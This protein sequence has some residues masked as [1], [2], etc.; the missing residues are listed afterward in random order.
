MILESYR[1]GANTAFYVKN[2]DGSV[3]LC[4]YPEDKAKRID[5][6]NFNTESMVQVKFES[7]PSFLEFAEGLTMLSSASVHGLQIVRQERA[8][9][10]VKTVLWDGKGN[11]FTHR[12]TFHPQSNV[13]ETDVTY[14]NNS[15]ENRVLEH[16]SSFA[17]TG[18]K[19]L[20]S[21]KNTVEGCKLHRL[22][23]FWSA[24]GRK[25]TAP[26]E[27]LGLEDSW[28]NQ[29]AR[30]E[31]FGQVGSM[32]VRKYFPFAC[33]EE[34][35]GTCWAV[36]FEAPYSW[37][38]EVLVINGCAT[39][40]GGLADYEFGHWKKNIAPGQS[41][42]TRR[43]YLSVDSGF[44]QV[45][46]N[47]VDFYNKR[48]RVP[49]CEES[50]PIICNEYCTTYGNP[51]EDRVKRLALAAKELGAEYFIIDAGWYKKPGINWYY[52]IGDWQESPEFFPSGLK[53]LVGYIK[54]LGLKPGIWF[55]YENCAIDSDVY[56]DTSLLL[57]RNG[58]PLNTQ[59]RRFFDLRK[60][61]V[62]EYF[63]EKVIGFLR[64]NGF[65]YIKV[66]YNGNY[67][68]GCD[69]AE[70]EE[71][72]GRQVAEESIKMFAALSERIPGLVVENCS[73]GGHRLEPAR[74]EIASMASFSDAHECIE[75]PILAANVSRI[76]P[77]RQNQIWATLKNTYPDHRLYHLLLGNFYGR[78][79]LS[80]DIDTLT[81]GQ[82]K[83]CRE[84]IDFYRELVP[85][86]KEGR[87]I[88]LE[89]DVAG[90]RDPKGI[91]L[92]EIEYGRKKLLLLHTFGESKAGEICFSGEI[93]KIVGSIPYRT[94][95]RQGKRYI[96]YAAQ[97]FG[98]LA[99]L[100]GGGERNGK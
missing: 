29:G 46:A 28:G 79:C 55:E 75:V 20:L 69:G 96:V 91:Q 16:L 100:I 48:L 3:G 62:K 2:R 85:L 18:I 13:F 9:D 56:A 50:M 42:Q 97:D 90:Y 27:E 63:Q 72:A 53:N 6:E 51:E 74:M 37:Q 33:V 84:C 86:L 35:S 67:G 24:E 7:D 98:A 80:G 31:K 78:L 38:A 57:K 40:S 23:S 12:L 22:T 4:I 59:Y 25:V 17:C 11:E 64:R 45:C 34:P 83:I 65:E 95:E 41:F 10:T 36:N 70:S 49:Q 21:Q 43:A 77:R 54:G 66:D 32:P 15:E 8:S 52:S 39:L 94:E 30:T 58:I 76:I 87:L 60:Q 19:N 26:F 82:R 73:S 89:C 81:D 14:T 61:E 44:D 88:R 1:F 71:E 68:R 5:F 47:L 93:E 92:G 99:V